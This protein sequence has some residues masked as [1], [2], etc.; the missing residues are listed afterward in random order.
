MKSWLEEK[1]VWAYKKILGD[2]LA[3][4]LDFKNFF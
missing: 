3:Y 1:A 4:D 2:L